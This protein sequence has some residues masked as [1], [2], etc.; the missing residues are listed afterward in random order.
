VFD[1]IYVEN[2][3]ISMKKLIFQKFLKDVFKSFI[4]ITFSISL[5]V[6][7]IQAVG[8]LDFVT[9][10][11]HSL[12]IYFSY[13]FFN[14]PKI[15]HR[16]LPF[17]FFI[18]LFFTISQYEL[19]NELILYWSNG[20]TK[21]QFINVIIL[22]SV[23]IFLFQI[24]LGS[25]V[26][27]MSQDKSR[28][29]LRSSNVDFFPSLIKPGKFIDTVSNLTIFIKSKNNDGLFENI[30]LH[31]SEKSNTSIKDKKSQT[32]Q[33]K[34]GFLVNKSSNRYFELYNGSITNIENKK[35]S[36]VSFEKIKFDLSKYVSQTITYP[37][38]QESPSRD[39]FNCIYYSYKKKINK[40]TAKFLRCEKSSLGNIKEEFI[41]R[42]FKPF[43]L[44]TVA[45]ICSLLIITSKENKNYDY[46][47]LLLFI[48]V[49]FI[50]IISEVS[51]RY[52]TDSEALMLGII[53]LPLIF[54]LIIYILL[55]TKLMNKI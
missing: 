28:S 11:G 48:A 54:F 14:F 45:L 1:A 37:K 20:I 19:N 53:S 41:K 8:F 44:F 55:I 30:F 35:I 18:S 4:I 39:L 13:T 16:I 24:F 38:I 12:S 22:Y 27:P 26:S 49:F 50:I 42:F 10:D 2:Y 9:S 21:V 33:A 47:R 23:L 15:I 7:V 52:S 46:Y 25:Y 36:N 3:H 40:F 6:W 32:I 17:T 43:Y 34:N 29:F 51:L 5:I 31:E